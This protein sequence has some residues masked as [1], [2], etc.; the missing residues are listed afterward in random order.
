MS[1]SNRYRPL[2]YLFLLLSCGVR[3][4]AE[5][6]EL[7]FELD[8]PG[9]VIAEITASAPSTSWERL[10]AEAA[11]ATVH[12]DGHY[13]QD[14]ILFQGARSWTYRVFLGPLEAGTHGLRVVQN[15]RWSAPGAG[16]RVE[17]IRVRVVTDDAPDYRALAHAPI[18]YARADTL[19][20]FSDVPLLMW[21]E[22]DSGS[23]GEVLQYSVIFSNEDGGT[24]TDALMARWG[25]ATDIEYVYRV[26]LDSHGNVQEEVF[27]GPSHKEG[28]FQGRRKAHHPFL[29]VATRNNMVM[30]T[31]FSP[32]QFHLAPVRADLDE[33]SREEL[34]DRFPWTYRIMAQELEREG[35]LRPYDL[36]NGPAISD[37]R[38]YL[39]VEL[40]A[41][42]RNSGSTAW[43][44]LKGQSRWHSSHKG[45]D[46]FAISRNGWSRTTVELP[47]GTAEEDIEL[48]AFQCL[49]LRGVDGDESR[50]DGKCDL[51]E[52]QKVFLLDSEYRPGRNLLRNSTPVSLRPGEMYAFPLGGLDD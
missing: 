13:N 15:L 50:D 27:Q 6:R 23:E 41:E 17:R 12:V 1:S 47:P 38:Q 45:R 3:L 24:A 32:L 52:V 18:L 9:E 10:G 36:R 26:R 21:Y 35:K 44:K 39:Y 25:R 8:T 46:E 48:I 43:V 20:R 40:R 29:L 2:L 11:V 19:G 14:L 31:G 33:N 22:Q 28:T 4:Y 51:Q 16:L 34:M 49:D 5:S 7:R 30:D 42:H 37:P